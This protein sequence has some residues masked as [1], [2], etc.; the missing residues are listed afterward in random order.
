MLKKYLCLLIILFAPILSLADILS[1]N[2]DNEIAVM[3]R[4]ITATSQQLEEQKALETLM[5]LFRVQKQQFI[6]GNETK[7]QAGL[8]VKTARQI[9]EKIE[10]L[11]LQHL[12]S[13]EY[14]EELALFSSIAGKT[15]PRRP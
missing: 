11:H 2:S 8:I 1:L 14:M 13:S 10:E 3:D 15:A 12:F 7:Q 4:L 9:L 5:R 6:E